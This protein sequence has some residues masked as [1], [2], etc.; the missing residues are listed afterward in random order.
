VLQAETRLRLRGVPV[1]VPALMRELTPAEAEAL[2][3]VGLPS[4]LTI[5]GNHQACHFSER[6]RTGCALLM[7]M[8]V[9]LGY[10]YFITDGGRE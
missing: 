10:S 3:V 1:T 5:F 8:L 9:A 4:Y 2:I 7:T 6:S